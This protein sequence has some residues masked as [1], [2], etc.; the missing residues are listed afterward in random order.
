MSG[1]FQVLYA[2]CP[3]SYNDKKPRGGAEHHYSTMSVEVL[4]KLPFARI[5]ADDAVLFSW[6][7]NPL[8]RECV[9]VGEA[10]GFAYKTIAF[11]W[12]KRNEKAGTPFFGLG[13]WTRGNTENCL[14]FTRGKP[15]RV[16]A[17]VSQLIETFEGET[18]DSPIA[19]HS[20]KPAIVRDRIVQLMGDVPRIELFAR[21]H[22]PGWHAW[23]N[24][25]PP[26]PADSAP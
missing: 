11:T 25:L 8:I 4:C 12:V 1:R 24:Q 22:T 15:K 2:D 5:A 9:R 16:D 10:W 20:E 18:L 7:T 6:G 14:L 13:R 26:M 23:G 21:Q 19:R 17:S 3:W